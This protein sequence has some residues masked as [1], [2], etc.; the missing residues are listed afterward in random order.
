MI[1]T[2]LG[3]AYSKWLNELSMSIEPPPVPAVHVLPG[4]LASFDRFRSCV[5]NQVV[6]DTGS[7]TERGPPMEDGAV[8]A[9]PSLVVQKEHLREPY[10]WGRVNCKEWV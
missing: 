5:I 7:K 1:D 8:H 6:P 4:E 10:T 3:D 2:S 9:T